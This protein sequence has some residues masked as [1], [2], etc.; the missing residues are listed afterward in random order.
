MKTAGR[1]LLSGVAA[2]SAIVVAQS[3]LRLAPGGAVRWASGRAS[4]GES[5]AC[6]P[7]R[8]QPVARAVAGAAARLPWR[9][10]CLD[11]GIALVLLLSI[12][13][14]RA[15]LVVGVSRDDASIRAHAWVE[16]NGH[17]ILGAD[18]EPA[19][20]ALPLTRTFP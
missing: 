20:A 11:Q 17:V 9:A 6:L 2:A 15:R 4:R 10:S 8:I 19:F 13:G 16:C 14:Q 5:S 3:W 1:R 12:T 7:H 18:A